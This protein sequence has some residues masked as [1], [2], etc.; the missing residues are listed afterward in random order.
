MSRL[1]RELKN[2][3]TKNEIVKIKNSL[4]KINNIAY[5]ASFS[6][7]SK[8]IELRKR[9]MKLVN[10]KIYPLNKI[11]FLVEDCKKFGTLPFAG[12]ARCG[13]IAIDILNSLVDTDIIS[14][15][16]KNNY[17]NSIVNIASRVSN[18][19]IK[20]NKNQFCKIYGHLRPNTYDIT[21]LIIPKDIISILI[22]KKKY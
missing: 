21:R 18:D 1:N 14:L 8:I 13:F 9:Q 12:L 22:L 2:N 17:L 5:K 19:Y 3:F 7:L 11:Y 16:D 6:D 15:N 20:L 10:S 4:I